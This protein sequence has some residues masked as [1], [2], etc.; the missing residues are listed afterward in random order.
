MATVR[1]PPRQVQKVL[2]LEAPGGEPDRV[3]AVL[4]TVTAPG[5]AVRLKVAVMDAMGYPSLACGEAVRVR[6][7]FGSKDGPV[8][9]AGEGEVP[10]GT[11]SFDALAALAIPPRCAHAEILTEFARS[12]N[13]A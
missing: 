2:A 13:G 8:P 3:L 6:G 11:G 9:V 12:R 1:Y 5:R 7:P 10:G 4:P